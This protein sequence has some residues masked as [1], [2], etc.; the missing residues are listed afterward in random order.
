VT[1]PKNIPGL[2]M[3]AAA[4]T[5]AAAAALA[6]ACG[7]ESADPI[8]DDGGAG[9]AGPLPTGDSGD[10]DD[11]HDPLNGVDAGCPIKSDGPRSGTTAASVPRAGVTGIAWGT[12]E[13]ARNLDTQFA[14]ATLD[15]TQ[16]SE[17]LRI[18]D[19]GFTIPAS[20]QIKGVEVEFKRQAG[21]T[22]I[23]DG[24]IELWLDGMPSDRPKF[25]AT[26]WPRLIVGTHHYGQA[27]DTWGNDL[28]PALVGK[29]GFGVEIFAKRQ[30]DAGTGPIEA[31]V[32]SMRITI[33]YCD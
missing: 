23:A 29:P 32:E 13:N 18:T 10:D 9:D 22:G 27:V 25:V 2:A 6:V 1:L 8:A 4:L 11:A 28:T 33:F 17:H 14:R 21:D 5:L 31:T 12:P 26:S 24:N 30:E 16:T 15:L 7:S 3:V 19:F 20:A